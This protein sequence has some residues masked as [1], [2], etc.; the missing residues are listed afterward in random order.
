MKRVEIAGLHIEA[1]SGAPIVLL[2][3]HDEPHR[4]LPIFIGGP[5]A[6]SIAIALSGQPGPRPLT[7]DLMADLVESLDARVDAVEVTNLQD[8]T[9]VAAIALTSPAGTRRLD[10]RPSDAI[11]LAVRV[12]AP[13]YV[14]DDVMDEAAAVLTE[15]DG[16]DEAAAGDER[17]DEEQI[18]EAVAEFRDFLDELEPGDF[19]DLAP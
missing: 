15:S 18:D 11:A 14:S 19:E 2:R 4:V 5:E 13:L 16:S 12:D 6:A 7:H 9:F 17:M 3:E 1:N 10:T 8:G